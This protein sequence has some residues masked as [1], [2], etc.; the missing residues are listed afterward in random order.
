MVLEDF[1]GVSLC[2]RYSRVPN[3]L[4]FCGPSDNHELFFKCIIGGECEKA[5][6]SLKKFEGLYPYLDFIAKKHAKKPFDY[7]VVE[8]YWTGNRL[9]EGFNKEEFMLHL[10]RLV[11]V[12]LPSFI[13]EKLK[14][15]LPEKPFPMHLFNVVFVGVGNIT[16]AVTANIQNMDNCRI[17]WAKVLELSEK[18]AIVKY[19]PLIA[20]K[21]NAV[22]GKEIE[23][24]VGF[25]KRIADIAEGDIVT[26][27][28]NEICEI[29]DAKRKTKIELYTERVLSSIPRFDA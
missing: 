8:A 1:S 26:I 24:K 28:W 3:N 2:S 23:K 20:D 6:L 13:A 12:G 10:D 19:N 27:H 5:S 17:Y 29:I 9:L 25:D 4:G 11:N 14:N 21:E 18:T 16:G 7:E 22:I 15:K